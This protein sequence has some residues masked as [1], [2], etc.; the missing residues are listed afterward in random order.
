M[1]IEE[2]EIRP[3]SEALEFSAAD[4]LLKYTIGNEWEERILVDKSVGGERWCVFL[5]HDDN[6][7]YGCRIQ[8]VKPV[9]CT[10]FPYKWRT[11]DAFDWCE[12][13]LS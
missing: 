10:N 5:Q 2:E 4:F 6:G 7:N 8:A 9:Q 12:G 1:R 11:R 13:L 3:I